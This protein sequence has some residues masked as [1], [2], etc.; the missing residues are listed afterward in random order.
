MEA[1]KKHPWGRP[2]KYK[3]F[4]VWLEKALNEKNDKWE[5]INSI[6]LTDEELFLLANDYLDENDRIC[7]MTFKNFKASAIKEEE[8]TYNEFLS[9]YKKAIL[10]QKKNLF[11]KLQGDEWQWQ[12][13]AWIIERK[14]SEWNLKKVSESTVKV[15]DYTFSSNIDE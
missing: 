13:Y 8:D 9:L 12:K 6:I 1:I 14:F 11:D 5:W 15:T 10:K 2:S 3:N 4:L 7:Y